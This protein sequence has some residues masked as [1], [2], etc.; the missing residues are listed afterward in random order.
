MTILIETAQLVK[1]KLNNNLDNLTIERLVVGLFFTGVKLSNGAGGVCYTPIKDI[2]EAVCCPSSAGQIFH[3]EKVRGIKT[4]SVLKSL[5]SL[6]PIKTASAIATLNALSNT[7][8]GKGMKC[9]YNIHVNRDAQDVIN[10]SKD[11]SIALIGAIVPVLRALKE[12]GGTWWVIEQDPRTL[13]DDEM[14]HFIRASESKEVI[15]GADVLIITGV[16]LVNHTLDGILDMA[17]HEAEIAIMGPTASML[18]DPLFNRGVRVIGGVWVKNA[19][20]LLDILAAGGSGYHF[21]DSLAHRIVIE[22]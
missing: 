4:E 16:T 1:E 10:M 22:K 18:P 17:G 15:R 2:P 20:K 19:D 7:V 6:E 5:S 8:W 9:D 21:L 12:R 13:K 3:P 14:G 11:R